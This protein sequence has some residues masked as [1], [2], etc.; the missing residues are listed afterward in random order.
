MEK[1]ERQIE[2]LQSKNG[3]V[4]GTFVA[5]EG[6]SGVD[7]VPG[8][9]AVRFFQTR[10]DLIAASERDMRILATEDHEQLAL[11]FVGTLQGVVVLSFAESGSVDIGC[12]E[13][14][15]GADIRLHG[16]TKGKVAAETDAHHAKLAC[17]AGHRS[18]VVKGCASIR[19]IRAEFLCKLI[20]V[21]FACTLLVVGK[22]CAGWFQFVIDLRD[23]N[24]V[25]MPCEE[26]GGSANGTGE[27]KDF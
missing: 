25:T 10:A 23:S 21:P 3:V 12:V 1:F 4:A 27:L 15:S 26:G 7:F 20:E 14:G 18:E 2:A 11:Y 17:A 24:D 16:G 5:Q 13:T 19:I 8:V 6:M 9:E 22:N